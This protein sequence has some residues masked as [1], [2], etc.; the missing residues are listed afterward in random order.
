MRI[1]VIHKYIETSKSIISFTMLYYLRN[2][3]RLGFIFCNKGYKCKTTLRSFGKKY[4]MILY[5][6]STVNMKS[7]IEWGSR[8]LAMGPDYFVEKR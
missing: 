3:Y 7:A 8:G 2:S 6:L 4:F 1:G 5:G